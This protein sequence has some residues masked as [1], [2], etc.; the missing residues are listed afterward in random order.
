MIA[1]WSGWWFV[2][3][4]LPYYV[5]AVYS[6]PAGFVKELIINTPAVTGTWVSNPR[7]DKKP[8]L[9]L[10]S[11]T[12]KI[13]ALENPDESDKIITILDLRFDNKDL[14]T[15]G[16]R[17]IQGITAHPNFEEN[18][19]VYIFYPVYVE[20]CPEKT[21]D[22]PWN[23][24]ARFRMD[25]ETLELDPD[26]KEEIWRGGKSYKNVH[27]GG[28]MAFG[29]DNKLYITTGDSGNG[30]TVQLLNNV[31]GSIIRLNDDGSVPTDNPFADPDEYNSY[32]CADTEGYVPKDAPDDAICSEVF[33]NGLRNPFRMAMDPNEKEKVKF[34][35]SD[36]GGAY[37]EELDWGG[38]DFRGRNYGYPIHE[39]PC[40]HGHS[41]RCQLPGDK[42]ILEPFHW[43]EHRDLREGGCVSG[44]AIVPNNVGWPSEYKFLYADFIFL[45]IYN[46]IEDTDSYCRSCRPPNSN[47][48]NETFYKVPEVDGIE[49]GGI[50]DIFFGPY[51]DTQALYVIARD[52]SEQVTRIR[53]TEDVD[54]R[55]PIPKI[56]LKDLDYNYTVGEIFEFDG[57]SSSDVDGDDL[58]YVW[59]FDDGTTST[60]REP[61]HAFEIPGKYNVKLVVTDTSGLSQ[62]TSTLIN[63]GKPP[64]VNILS[65]LI[66]DEF[67]VG[68]IFTL[69]GE[70]LD[71]KGNRLDDSQLSWEVH[72]HHADHYHPFLDPT[73]G[74]D[75]TLFPAPEPED[76]FA[77][78]NSYLRVILK[79]TDNDGLTTEVD[80]LIQPWKIDVDI[81]SVPP[82]IEMVVDL[83]PLTTSNQIVSWKDHQ[84]SVLAQDQPPY[85]F[86]AWWDGNTE[87][88]RKIKLSDTKPTVLAM[89][90][91]QDYWL[92]MSN[93]E[94]CSGSCVS[95]SCT[96]TSTS[97]RMDES[98]VSKSEQEDSDSANEPEFEQ[99]DDANKDTSEEGHPINEFVSNML[100]D[101]EENTKKRF[102]EDD[103][104][105]LVK[106]V[107]KDVVNDLG[108]SDIEVDANEDIFVKNEDVENDGVG[109][110]EEFIDVADAKEI[111]KT[112]NERIDGNVIIIVDE[113]ENNYVSSQTVMQ[114]DVQSEVDKDNNVNAGLG[115]TGIVLIILACL[116]ISFIVVLKCY[117]NTKRKKERIPSTFSRSSVK[118]RGILKNTGDFK[119]NHR[120]EENCPSDIPDMNVNSAA[121]KTAA[122]AAFKS[123][124]STSAWV[125]DVLNSTY[126]TS[127][128]SS[129]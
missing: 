74:N 58:N 117:W 3:L 45:E 112:N 127:S 25:P 107:E 56:K 123:V 99:T 21:D 96:S 119:S 34:H 13:K 39:G 12:G 20:G 27:N 18:L 47:Y 93:E 80:R 26:S 129:S 124:D 86:M 2:P 88:K 43:Y 46:L 63:I 60:E 5:P 103:E 92:C 77:S 120:D 126:E 52:G 76:F 98:N 102:D 4:L 81:E 118:T 19:L 65:P 23:I 28:A 101:D 115:I 38:D 68:Q 89:Y 62:Q 6:L 24:V 36:V 40:L 15:N 10:A 113:D 71:F 78:T 57:S 105:F 30:D 50:T 51:K 72:K 87:R 49:R 108:G 75:L 106:D 116:I 9:I 29:I 41:N 32:R 64:T 11:K 79:A 66:G 31:H 22:A 61:K 70:A 55:P 73:N 109:S 48:K 95:M 83:Y 91:S 37:W 84:L 54:N 33:A 82:G 59:N 17:G 1:R 67:S 110:A 121:N 97:E 94:C 100:A 128:S 114:A 42:N 69:Q 85:E 14:C 35:I 111:S 122:I 104:K 44:A 8:M 16:E 7:Q 53:Y 125:E 90:C